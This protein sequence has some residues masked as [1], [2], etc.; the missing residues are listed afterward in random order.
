VGHWSGVRGEKTAQVR[1][2]EPDPFIA[3]Y[4][5]LYQNRWQRDDLSNRW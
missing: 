2:R 1:I 5:N 4:E 3:T